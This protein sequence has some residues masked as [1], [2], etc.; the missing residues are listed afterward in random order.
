MASNGNSADV[1]IIGA[2]PIGLEIAVGLKHAG[3]SY[4]HFEAGQVGS[5]LQW[6]APG[7]RFFSSPE[8]I[9]IA[10]V[11]LTL[12][13]QDKATREEY[14][15]YLRGVARQ[16]E[17]RIQTQTRVERVE[18]HGDD[19]FEIVTSASAHGVGGPAWYRDSPSREHARVAEP[20]QR[21]WRARHLI[22]A[23]G[24]MHR[25]RLLDVPGENLS[26]VSHYLADPHEYFG[27]RVLIVG[28]KNS[29]VEAAIRLHRVGAQVALS[30]RG[31]EF[32]PKRV[33]Y[34][35]KPELEWL[36]S[37]NRIAFH[38][39]TEV[40]RIDAEQVELASL[41]TGECCWRPADHVLLLTGY[42]QDPTLFKQI[43]I[44]L[45]G[46]E[47]APNF[48]LHTMQTNVPNV[49]VA[50]TAAGGSQRRA[51]LFI[52]NSHVHAARIVREIA[53][54]DLPWINREQYLHMEES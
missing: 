45:T 53:G 36:I 29:A 18:R 51:R 47:Q 9:E 41:D 52:E 4:V 31:S 8:R 13:H 35:L 5:T 11:P 20:G 34:W 25:P 17:L 19:E 42:V 44:E 26:H 1:A 49:Y 12:T 33:K 24:D 7:T 14:L 28:G 43:G 10:G 21:W 15:A 22:L 2:G 16:F 27:R 23:I 37:K 50:G 38:P 30:Y 6:W 48:D 54:V 46:E 39:R 40:R 32:D 3:V